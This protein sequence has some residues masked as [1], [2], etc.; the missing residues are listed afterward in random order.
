MPREVP[1]SWPVAAV[2]AQAI[3]ARSY[4]EFSRA[5]TGSGSYYDIC[6]TTA[7]QSYGG[8]AH[9]DASGTC[10]GPRIPEP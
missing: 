8:M 6:D 7:C 10:S 1:A 2:R 4:A 3:A 9:Y 5:A